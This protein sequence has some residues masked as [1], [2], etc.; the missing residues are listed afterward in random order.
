[1]KQETAKVLVSLDS[2]KMYW[3]DTLTVTDGSGNSVGFE[4]F[5]KVGTFF[6]TFYVTADDKSIE[7]RYFVYD[8]FIELSP[9]FGMEFLSVRNSGSRTITVKFGSSLS[10]IAPGF[11]IELENAAEPKGI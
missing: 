3:F 10:E 6:D 5:E 4:T 8:S 1:M 2:S 11:E 9:W 7:L